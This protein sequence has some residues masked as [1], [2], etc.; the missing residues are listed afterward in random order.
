MLTKST[1]DSPST[2]H[3]PAVDSRGGSFSRNAYSALYTTD[4]NV[5]QLT[6]YGSVSLFVMSDGGQALWGYFYVYIE[7]DGVLN[8]IWS[9]E[10]GMHWTSGSWSAN[11]NV[12]NSFNV[13]AGQHTIRLVFK[14]VSCFHD[15]WSLWR[16]GETTVT[17]SIL[18]YDEF[19]ST[20]SILATGT[21]AYMALGE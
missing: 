18:R 15:Y 16:I 21:L 1:G 5:N 19:F 10:S 6:I 11:I 3:V 2:V 14:S 4:I 12:N 20:S 7:I 9:D 8:L 17:F 13:A